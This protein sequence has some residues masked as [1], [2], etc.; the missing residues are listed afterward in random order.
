ML[1]GTVEM[2][3]AGRVTCQM[4]VLSAVALWLEEKAVTVMVEEGSSMP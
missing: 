4:P 2:G 1:V 3:C